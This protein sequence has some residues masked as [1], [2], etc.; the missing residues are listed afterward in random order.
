M[1]HIR[2][3]AL[4]GTAVLEDFFSFNLMKADAISG[5]CFIIHK[6][7]WCGVVKLVTMKPEPISSFV[8][9][10]TEWVE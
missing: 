7:C 9:C 4:F 10:K 8:V 6:V 1:R 2:R 5:C 3:G